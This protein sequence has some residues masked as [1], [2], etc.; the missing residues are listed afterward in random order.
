[1]TKFAKWGDVRAEIVADVGGEERIAEARQRNQAHIDGY[2]L[3]ERRK[4]L[5]LS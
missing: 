3:A 5:S 2:R 4:A 1:M